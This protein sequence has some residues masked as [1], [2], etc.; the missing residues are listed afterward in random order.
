VSHRIL[1]KPR[2][3]ILL[4]IPLVGLIVFFAIGF[5]PPPLAP[6]PLH[7][8]ASG[9]IG[10]GWQ[11]Y[12]LIVSPGD[13]DQKPNGAPDIIA[14]SASDGSAW[15]FSGDGLG[16]Y[17]GPT[18]IATDWG[19]YTM[20][21]GIG[22]FRHL[23]GR[24]TGPNDLL[25]VRSDGYLVLLPNLG[26]G[27]IGAPRVLGPGFG[28]YD[29]I[30]GAGD[31]NGDWTLDVIARNAS[32]GR[33]ILYAGDG[34]GGFSGHSVIS[35]V[36]F[37][38]YS[39]LTAP[40][41][42]DNDNF[43]DLVARSPDGTL[44]LFRGNGRGSLQ[45]TT[46]I[47]VGTGWNA[48]NAIVAPG[49][50]D[51]DNQVDL[52]ART[53]DGGIWLATGAGIS[54]YPDPISLTQ[55]STIGLH[56]S[57]V[58]SNYTIRFQRF[59]QPAPETVATLNET[60]G[61]IQAIPADAASK[62]ARWQE[63]ASYSDTCAWKSGLYAAQ[64]TATEPISST[65]ASLSE[66][67][68]ITFVVKPLGPPTPR[69]LLVVASTNTWTAYNDWPQ[70]SSF[71]D[72]RPG[73]RAT[74]VSYLRPNPGATPLAEGSHIAGGELQVLQWLEAHN[75]AYQ[76]V[77]DV[78]LNDNPSL[79][80]TSNYYAV[81]LNTHSEYWT[82]P[83]YNEVARY[84][85]NGGSVLSL[86][87]NTMYR[88]E[89]L[90]RPSQNAQWSSVLIGGVGP[91]RSPFAV[92]NLIGLQFV[93][94]IDTCAPY[95]VTKPKSWLMAG[96]S[97]RIIG[98]T[99]Q[100]WPSGCFL[101]APGIPAGA[102]GREVDKR[103]PFLLNRHYEVVAVGTNPKRGADLVWYMR[104]AG[105]Q[106]VNVGSIAFGNSLAID[107]N[108]SIIVTNALNRFMRF[109][110][111]GQST[112]GGLIAPGD[113]HGDGRPD[114]LAR[115]GDNLYLYRSNGAA[116]IEG[117]TFISAGWSQYDLI[118]PAGNWMGHARPDLLARR[119]SDGALFVVPN[120]GFGSFNARAR[121]GS[122]IHWS[123]YDT[124]LGVGDWNGDHIPDL[125]ARTPSGDLYLYTGLGG[126]RINPTPT[127]LATGW[128]S[129]DQ[130]ISPV[131]WNGDGLPDLIARK[132]DGS[133]W[134]ALGRRDHTLTAPQEMPHPVEWDNY[135]T[136]LSG[137]DW[138]AN[139]RH[140]L[141]ARRADGSI[142]V[143]PAD[144]EIFGTPFKVAERWNDFS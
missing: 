83:M 110:D 82:D 65:G 20:L 1:T 105:G 112:F 47:P 135:S 33:L 111:S 9:P 44:C 32:D 26:H 92:G 15:L 28:G 53:P 36:S 100:Y 45:N 68:Y 104:R 55:C 121:I 99:G 50:W 4:A 123:N 116:P 140:D 125:I 3:A 78:D 85:Q 43:R 126:G 11:K 60:N 127:L 8:R 10:Y 46:C 30:M 5:A 48:F 144:G 142:W 84:L 21:V 81:L 133:M 49:Q 18:R 80:S 101:N 74:Q 114:I 17:T 79:L 94:T 6:Q 39:L 62:G 40:G 134:I 129:Y 131:D 69:Q 107:P 23:T 14:R 119:A 90:L 137:G 120:S 13:W 141:I 97:A 34:K 96:V 113:L 25:A 139:G 130:I 16:G 57:S 124:I 31:F 93:S 106:V 95:R 71:Y 52:L 102:S 76:M 91:I 7:V 66:T 51:Q 2:V 75:F 73:H 89:T 12:D 138:N 35:P 103:L 59:G 29:V 22:G 63:S 108:L 42:W 27:V 132:P 109:H 24:G 87:G 58:T 41:D 54:G 70:D 77:T 67:A 143:F 37:A 136:V 72:G 38:G 64:L 61:Q 88:K 115:R 117:P 98:H 86:S 56:I 118:A 128:D 122:S 19:K